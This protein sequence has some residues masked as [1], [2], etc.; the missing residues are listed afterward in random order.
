MLAPHSVFRGTDA[1]IYMDGVWLTNVTSVEA[2]VEVNQAELNLLGHWWTAYRNMGLAGSGSLNGVFVNTELIDKIGTIQLGQEFR[3]ELVLKNVNPDTGKTYRVRLQNVVF[4]TIPLANF[5]AGEIV[6]Q[7]FP[8]TF[9][10]YEVLDK[11]V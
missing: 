5:T 6:E 11:V 4:S 9:S 8:F 2:S 10:G 1:E 7:E 3:T